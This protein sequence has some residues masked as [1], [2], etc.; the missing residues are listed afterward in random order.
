MTAAVT[1]R[2]RCWFA[3]IALFGCAQHAPEASMS[4]DRYAATDAAL[5]VWEARFGAAPD[6][7]SA[8]ADLGWAEADDAAFET[9]CMATEADG[10]T[11]VLQDGPTTIVLRDERWDAAY[12]A[13]LHAHELAH[14]LQ[15]CSGRVPGGDNQHADPEVFPGMVDAMQREMRR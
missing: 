10:C 14:W 3:A 2:V 6:C 1:A 13:W 7:W 9:L 8:R 11:V 4:I 15:H 5:Q 12:A